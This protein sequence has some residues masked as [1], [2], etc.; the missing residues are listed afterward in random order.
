LLYVYSPGSNTY[1]EASEFIQEK[2]EV[3]KPKGRDL[4]THRTNA[5]DTYNINVV[6]EASMA[7]VLRKNL[8]ATGLF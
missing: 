6:F 3:L 7:S 5:T 2:Y 4:Y 8:E 1:D